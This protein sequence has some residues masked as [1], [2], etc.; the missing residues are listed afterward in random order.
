MGRLVA[1][2]GSSFLRG[3]HQPEGSPTRHSK[4]GVARRYGQP[5]GLE[6]AP[7]ALDRSADR[8]GQD[9][10]RMLPIPPVTSRRK[11][12]SRPTTRSETHANES[13]KPMLP[14]AAHEPEWT[15]NAPLVWL[16]D[17]KPGTGLGPAT[18]S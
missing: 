11:A 18:L 6:L 16:Y 14:K 9:L 7:S 13:S 17:E 4:V 3:S 2:P 5:H 15:T 10:S 8:A 12:R 1:T